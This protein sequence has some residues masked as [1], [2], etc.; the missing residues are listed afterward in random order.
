MLEALISSRARVKL[1]TLF[2]LNP[3]NE[4]YIRE[5]VRMTGGN[6]N[7]VRRELQTSNPWSTSTAEKKE[8]RSITR[9]QTFL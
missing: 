6:I 1:L 7:A 4:F 3:E 2:L 5:I 9:Q 8:T